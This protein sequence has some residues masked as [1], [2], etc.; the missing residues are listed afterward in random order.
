MK[1]FLWIAVLFLL[2]ISGCSKK[3]EGCTPVSPQ[4]EEAQIT[5]YTSANGITAVKHSSGIYYQ[6]IDPGTG[7]TPTLYSKVYIS[8]TGK[9]LNGTQFD[10]AT[11]P[12]NT[13][14]TLGS[15]I[16]GWQIGL[17]LIKKGG[18]IKLIIP[19]SLAYGCNGAGSTIPS[20]AVLYFDISLADVQ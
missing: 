15:L 18:R 2:T 17:P 14:W 5:A 13:G 16:E 6:V 9:L 19:S 7:A 12:N 1:N 20:N 3:Q 8:Y 10:Q 11:N 4:V